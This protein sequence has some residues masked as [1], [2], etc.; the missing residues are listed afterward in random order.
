M[1][2]YELKKRFSS[3]L[4]F[5]WRAYDTQI[6]RELKTLEQA[7]FVAGR[8]EKGD[9][10]PNRR[11]YAL[12]DSGRAA[13]LAWLQSP[14]EDT[15]YKSELTLRISSMHLIPHVS[16]E[17][18]LA[19]VESATL[20]YLAQLSKRRSELHERYG[21]L[22]IAEDPRG[23]GHQLILELDIQVAERKLAWIERVRS[24]ARIRSVLAEHTAHP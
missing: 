15:W 17:R 11:T 10:G 14:L 13:L 3:S 6:Y 24:V 23:V 12:T 8:A 19:G 22:E 7:G 18:I 1:S 2:G 21:Q 5:G 9:R 20:A 4:G 16:L